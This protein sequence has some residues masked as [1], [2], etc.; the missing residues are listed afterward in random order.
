MR[1][2]LGLLAR[3]EN[4]GISKYLS[5]RARTG[6]WPVLNTS[7]SSRD[8][9]LASS[10]VSS[11]RSTRSSA[12]LIWPSMAPRRFPLYDT[13]CRLT[14][15]TPVI[16][17]YLRQYRWSSARRQSAVGSLR[18]SF[19]DRHRLRVTESGLVQIERPR[20]RIQQYNSVRL[21]TVQAFLMMLTRQSAVAGDDGNLY[22][23]CPLQ[24]TCGR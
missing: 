11:G 7:I 22:Y 24:M 3:F 20:F 6:G 12:M 18:S 17:I 5:L 10:A 21:A 15:I 23:F 4:S 8:K 16:W 2:G 1:L 9:R 13:F 19:R 14:V